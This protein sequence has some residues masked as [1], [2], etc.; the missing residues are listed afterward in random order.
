MKLKQKHLW[1]FLT[2]MIVV[3]FFG[4]LYDVGDGKDDG[5]TSSSGTPQRPMIH[6]DTTTNT[7]HGLVMYENSAPTDEE[8]KELLNR[9]FTNVF[10]FSQNDA[11]ISSQNPQMAWNL[12]AICI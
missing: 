5:H 7:I 12:V 4:V 2:I 10:L 9:Y 6:H 3:V 11:I 8:F 1:I